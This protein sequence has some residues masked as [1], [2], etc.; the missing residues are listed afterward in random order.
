MVT[1]LSPPYG[2]SADAAGQEGARM[3]PSFL[4][5]Q[6]ERGLN[7]YVNKCASCH[8]PSLQGGSGTPLAGAPFQS[9]WSNRAL[10]DLLYVISTQMP[11]NA[12][13]SLSDDEDFDLLAFILHKNDYPSGPVPLDASQAYALLFEGGAAPAAAQSDAPP[14]DLPGPATLYG[15][16]QLAKPDD[17]DLVRAN[18]ADWLMYNR[19]YRGQRYSGLREIN[20]QTAARLHAVCAFQ[21]GQIGSYQ[22]SPVIYDGVL[23]ITAT[24]STYAIDAT[25]CRKYW[26]FDYVTSEP[27]PILSVNRGV[28]LYRGAIYRTTPSGHLIALDAKAGKLLWDVKVSD[29]ASGHWLA[30]APIAYDG[31]IFIGEAGADTGANGRVYAFDSATGNRLW[32]FDLVPTKSQ[33]GAETWQRGAATGG[34]STWTSYSLDPPARALYVPV[35]NP[36][37]NY[38]GDA[39]PGSNLFS[40]SIVALDIDTGRL[41]WY[42]QQTPH[43]VHDWDTAAPPTLFDIDRR[44]YVSVAT[45]GGWLYLYDRDSH[46]LLAQQEVSTHLNASAAP[47][48]QG[49]RTCPGILGGVQWFGPAFSP[50]Y[51]SLFVNSVEWCGKF[52]L[53]E[54]DYIRGSLYLGGQMLL[55]PSSQASGWIRSFDAATGEPR[56]AIKVATPMLAGLTA[57]AGD[58]LFTGDLNGDFLVL[59]ASSGKEL[60]RFNTGGAIAGGISTYAVHGRQYV[61]VASG[62]SSRVTWGS[63]GAATIFIFALP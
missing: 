17:A 26:Q 10:R 8:G 34:G 9:R 60:Y 22:A 41:I 28:A 11:L 54:S 51:R 1:V 55:D 45:K 44:Q 18:D 7:L 20:S 2:F 32:T 6:A 35:G 39:R 21:L 58:V 43:D 56:W 12:P 46:Q 47:T 31:K 38:A 42:A 29:S 53:K 27:P 19:D 16:A 25:T 48:T 4:S 30:A 62:N 57:T 23:Y 13:G 37:P 24:S 5:A 52:V 59:L 3:G 49:V 61:A 14:I 40:D 50:K 63:T 36:T 33:V 15:R